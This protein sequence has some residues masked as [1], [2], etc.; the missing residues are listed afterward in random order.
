M[1][2]VKIAAGN[3]RDKYGRAFCQTGGFIHA[4][5]NTS[6]KTLHAENGRGN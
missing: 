5:E 6:L 1:Q 4:D 2:A 3:A